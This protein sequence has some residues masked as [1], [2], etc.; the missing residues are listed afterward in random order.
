MGRFRAA[1]GASAH[2]AANRAQTEELEEQL[3]EDRRR[4]R[5]M[6]MQLLGLTPGLAVDDER[7]TIEERFSLILAHGSADDAS[8]DD[9]T[10]R[11]MVRGLIVA[12][13]ASDD[14]AKQALEDLLDA[15]AD[16]EAVETARTPRR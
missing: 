6:I 2:A 15:V 10:A 12:E 16:D 14:D 9:R 7:H 5:T 4:K 11:E 3:A 1:V 8:E 13:K